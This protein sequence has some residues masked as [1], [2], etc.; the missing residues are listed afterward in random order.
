VQHPLVTELL[1]PAPNPFNPS[2]TIRLAVEKAAS[3]RVEIFS[4]IGQRVAVLLDETVSPG[5][6]NLV[7][8]GRDRSGRPVAAGSYLVRAQ[9]GGEVF[10]RRVT[11]LK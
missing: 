7:W 11:L 3:A 10:I 5:Y 1:S 8:D 9:I 4:L 6:H 2:T